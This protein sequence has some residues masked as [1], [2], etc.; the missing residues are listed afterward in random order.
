MLLCAVLS[1][2]C[3]TVAE[4]RKLEAEVYRQRNEE[5]GG[6][7][8]EQLADLI[9]QV[10]SLE[11]EVARLRGDVELANHE[12]TEARQ[13]ARAAR[14]EAAAAATAA[15]EAGAAARGSSADSR[16]GPMQT[17]DAAAA[18]DVSREVGDVTASAQEV[19]AYRV[20]YASR[21]DQEPGQCI[22]RFRDFLQVYPSSVHADDATYW[23]ATCYVRQG[24]Y[25]T[26]ILRFDDVA[27][28]YPSGNRAPDALYQQGEAL[29]RLGPT[30]RKAASKAFERVVNEYPDSE[31]AAKAKAKLEEL[32]A[33]GSG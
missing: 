31:P 15:A 4:F 17:P 16:S 6:G 2:G 9:A 21:L 28:R 3:A 24:D 27:A 11:R 5:V 25:R 7:T 18:E 32:G 13:E 12:A 8:R 23:M 29:L 1:S 20:A 22:E 19:E 30:Y 14:E 33:Q 26:A 10:D